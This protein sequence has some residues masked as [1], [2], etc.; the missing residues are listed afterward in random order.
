MERK[1]VVGQAMRQLIDWITPQT[2]ECCEAI[3]ER[4]G[5]TG[6]GLAAAVL[7]R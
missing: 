2:I 6:N 4:R 5:C 3:E 1:N 7:R